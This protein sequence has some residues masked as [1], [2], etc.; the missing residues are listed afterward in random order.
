MQRLTLRLP[1]RLHRRLRE[2]ARGTGASL[3]QL[4]IEELDRSIPSSDQPAPTPGS[5]EEERRL[6]RIALKDGLVDAAG[7]GWTT[8]G[9]D[10]LE[11][12]DDAAFR[13][14]MPKLDPP[15]SRTIIEDREN[16]F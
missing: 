7:F 8:S 11:V 15:L 14:S 3:N 16:R 1:D 4:I 10:S 12:L 13:A 2:R 5:V 9:D 6:V